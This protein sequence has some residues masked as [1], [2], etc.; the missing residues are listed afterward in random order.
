M[1]FL[2]KDGNRSSCCSLHQ[3]RMH[4]CAKNIHFCVKYTEIAHPVRVRAFASAFQRAEKGSRLRQAM[5]TYTLYA[6][7]MHV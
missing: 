4:A 2:Y 3:R 1:Q 7:Y 6:C 5:T